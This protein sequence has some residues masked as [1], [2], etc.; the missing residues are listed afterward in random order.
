M[1]AKFFKKSDRIHA[2]PAAATPQH[3]EEWTHR[4]HHVVV[5]DTEDI[6]SYDKGSVMP[7]LIYPEEYD[8]KEDDNPPG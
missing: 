6:Y 3:R 8:D 5:T 4:S 7:P 1:I 2:C